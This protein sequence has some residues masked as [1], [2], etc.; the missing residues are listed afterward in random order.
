MYNYITMRF[1][2]WSKQ[3]AKLHHSW[4][5]V[6][7]TTFLKANI[8]IVNSPSL[9][10]DKENVLGQLLSWNTKRQSLLNLIL[11]AEEALSPR[12][13]LTEFPLN[14]LPESEIKWLSAVVHSVYLKQSSILLAV[15]QLKTTFKEVEVLI[16]LA[17]AQLKGEIAILHETCGDE[18][19]QKVLEL[20]AQI[21]ALPHTI[22]IPFGV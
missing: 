19:L 1:N 14:R 4:L 10:A 3:R 22:Q 11:N 2:E 7:Y 9:E 21:S 15:E 17:A 13:L 5:L 18:L 12:Q 6:I 16:E 20:S 8:D